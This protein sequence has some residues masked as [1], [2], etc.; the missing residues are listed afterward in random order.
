MKVILL[1][2]IEK[3]GHKYEIKEVSDGFAIYYLFPKK[4]AKPATPQNLAWLQKILE[5]Q[6]RKS[7]EELKALQELAQKIENTT[8]VLKA[9]ANQDGTLF[10]AVKAM[11]IA[12]ALKEKGIT[13]HRKQL[14]LEKPIKQ[15]GEYEI[16]VD[17]EEFQPTLKV[18]VVP[19]E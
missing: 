17:L 16:K 9:K 10:G 6:Q 13:I 1:E 7:E 18:Q 14:L 2:D 3:L 12:L 5:K 15:L 4:L 19:E 11:D 8:I